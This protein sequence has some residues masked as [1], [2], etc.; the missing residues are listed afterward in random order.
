[1]KKRR[2]AIFGYYSSAVEVASYLRSR[3]YLITIIDNQEENLAKARYMGFETARLDYQDDAE[4]KK[5]RLGEDIGTL[6]SLFPDDAENVY[7]TITA[8]A[9]APKVKIFTIGHGPLAIPKLIAAGADKVIDT[10]EITGRRIWN[11]LERPIITEILDHTLFGQANLSMAEIPL[12]ADSL[13]LGKMLGDIH[14]GDDYNLILV[15]VV[16]RD[17]SE[18]FIYSAAGKMHH[19]KEGDTLVIIGPNSQINSFR[20]DLEQSRR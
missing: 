14:F 9:L 8:R 15:G 3:D 12:Q 16:D 17:S 6:F 18:A 7:L 19:L 4:L 1:M 2:I 20:N 13:L 11:I 5:L 10:F